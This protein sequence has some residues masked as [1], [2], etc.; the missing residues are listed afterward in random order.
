MIM[1]TVMLALVG[2]FAFSSD[3]LWSTNYVKW[4][5]IRG[6]N[7]IVWA[8]VSA[9]FCFSCLTGGWALISVAF[10][11]NYFSNVLFVSTM[12]FIKVQ[13]WSRREQKWK[14]EEMTNLLGMK[15]AYH[16][17]KQSPELSVCSHNSVLEQ[18]FI[19]ATESSLSAPEERH[20]SSNHFG[21]SCTDSIRYVLN[22]LQLTFSLPLRLCK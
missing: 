19:D 17:R 2:A 15:S 14:Q 10:E 9:Y 4:L 21:S 5:Q 7:G 1:V 11:C 20:P 16:G 18:M 13:S 3:S 12:L 6:S 22:G 8:K